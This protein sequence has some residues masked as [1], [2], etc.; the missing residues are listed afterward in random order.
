MVKDLMPQLQRSWNQDGRNI[1][2]DETSSI[3]G[4]KDTLIEME[5]RRLVSNME[6]LS[7][8][9]NS[10]F[11]RLENIVD[12]IDKVAM[13]NTEIQKLHEVIWCGVNQRRIEQDKIKLKGIVADSKILGVK[14]RDFL[15][16]EQGD[17]NKKEKELDNNEVRHASNKDRHELQL[18]RTQ[19]AA[20]SKRFYDEWTVYNNLEVSFRDRLKDGY[21]RQCKTI[22]ANVTEDEIE[23][24]LDKGNME[25]LKF[26]I[27]DS[28]DKMKDQ[29][30]ELTKRRDQFLELEQAIVEIR[31]L[32]QEM[33]HLISEQ[34]ETIN[35]IERNVEKA[36]EKITVATEDLRIGLNYKQKARKKKIIC[37]VIVISVIVLL[38]IIVASVPT[39]NKQKP[40]EPDEPDETGLFPS[41]GSIDPSTS[42]TI[43]SLEPVINT[44][45]APIMPS[46]PQDG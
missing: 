15:K 12:D 6:S 14:I 44:D 25:G 3:G 27:L 39:G 24:M 29:V 35:N 42:T 23:A 2:T 17:I 36:D 16:T 46:I 37:F 1:N 45:S 18:K 10:F 22:N 28:S 33:A 8:Q 30:D 34:G 19:I 26:S 13:N 4:R 9:L 11:E 40:V 20:Q 41:F 31:D 5:T 32:F 7:T 38:V 21:R 43:A